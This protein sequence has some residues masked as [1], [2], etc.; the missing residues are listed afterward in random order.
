MLPEKRIAVVWMT[1]GEWI[2]NTDAV[3]NAALDV[4]LGLDPQPIKGKRSIAQAMIS[5]YLSRGIGAAIKQYETLKKLR[6]DA[7]NFDV[8]QLNGVGR[9]LLLYGYSKDAIR[10]FQ[11]NA[12]AYPSVADTFDALGEACEKDGNRT[13]A[14]SNYEK[15]LQLD[16]S[17]AHAADALKRL[18]K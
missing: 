11:L 5:T 10:I 6:P 14:I 3:T 1:N 15:A 7:Y 17:Q 16:R 9:Y 8:G 2:P 4:A 13:L 12:L 18:K